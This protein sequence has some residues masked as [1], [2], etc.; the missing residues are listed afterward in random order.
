MGTIA[1]TPNVGLSRVELDIQFATTVS[2]VRVGRR[3]PSGFTTLIRQGDPFTV[4][5]GRGLLYDYEA[6]L[7]VDISY[8]ATQVTPP[9]NEV[10]ASAT[11]K[12]ASDGHSWLKDPGLP[13]MNL[14]V[15]VSALPTL[16]RA[17]RGNALAV[18]G[19]AA[20]VVLTDIQSAPTGVVT[21]YSLTD[22]GRNGL[23]ALMSRGSVL[24][25]STPAAYG[26]GS[27][28]IVLGEVTENRVGLAPEASRTW[29]LPF[30]VV[31]RPPGLS[32]PATTKNLWSDVRDFY[33]A[34][35]TLTA[36]G[37]SWQVL[38]VEGVS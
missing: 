14:R 19:R 3:D 11:I 38:A 23:L 7:D 1:V 30:T 20:P 34:W 15:G 5:S 10:A 32:K 12:L 13:S 37:I 8:T 9:G 28:Y 33:G 6:P 22:T 36:R 25:L 18:V 21:L 16:T 2:Q 24:L 29:D 35:G 31:E 17:A 27:Q 26:F 4:T